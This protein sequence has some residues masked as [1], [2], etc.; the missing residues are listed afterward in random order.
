MRILSIHNL[1]KL[2]S[3]EE[4]SRDLET[5]ILRERGHQ[6]DIYDECN[7]HLNPES[8]SPNIA[9]RTIWSQE[10]YQ[11]VRK[12]L[13]SVKYDIVHV[14]NFF[15][16]ISPSVYYA[17][18]AEG[19]P[20]VQTLQN[21]RLLCPSGFLFREGKVCE[22]C[23]G[24][25]VPWASIAHAC[26]RDSRLA[27]FPVATMLAFHRALGTWQQQVDT[28]IALTHYDRQ[29]FIQGGLPAEKIAVKPNFVYPDPLPGKGEGNYAIFVGRLSPEKGIDTLL[30][31]WRVLGNQI[32]LKIVG[33]GPLAN[34]VA[35]AAKELPQIEWLGFKPMQEIYPLIGEAKFLLFPSKWNET[36]SRVAVE[37]LAKG[38]PVISAAG[39][40]DMADLIAPGQ[41]GLHFQPGDSQDL[42]QKVKWMLDHPEQL[43]SMR[44]H[45]RAAYANRYTG[46]K[47]YEMLMRI[48]ATAK[49]RTS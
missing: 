33:D 5:M 39:V 36:F 22:K 23:L 30:A 34:D 31:A 47:N 17:A 42:V 37:A 25:S 26:Y 32:P 11:K 7:G 48:Y 28:F 19:I 3:G 20:V 6:V 16:Q 45:A 21:F 40:T 44:Q 15:P 35:A 18:K 49:A 8:I 4:E 2:R 1:Y 14:H 9:L 43:A 24:K 13:Q 10:S 29:K 46:P 41:T 12:R 38:T 27:T